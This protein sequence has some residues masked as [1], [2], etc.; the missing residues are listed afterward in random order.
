MREYGFSLTCILPYKDRIYNYV[1][2]RENTGQWTPVFSHILCS[3]KLYI[4]HTHSCVIIII[5][6]LISPLLELIDGKFWINTTQKMKFYLLVNQRHLKVL[7]HISVQL[8][9]LWPSKNF[10][11]SEVFAGRC[12]GK[13]FTCLRVSFYNSQ[14]KI[15]NNLASK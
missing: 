14:E 8:N 7:S 3:N 2:I 11:T 1:L 12:F 4:F 10:K 5:I 6:S 9:V 13:K 15:K